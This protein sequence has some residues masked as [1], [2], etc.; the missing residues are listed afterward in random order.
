MAEHTLQTEQEAATALL[1][2]CALHDSTHVPQSRIEHL[3]R[4]MVLCT[5]FRGFDL[6]DL[7]AK[8]LALFSQEGAKGVIEKAAPMI[9]EDFRETLFAMSCELITDNGKVNEVESELL[10]GIALF[11]GMTMENMRMI[12]TT[13]LIRNRFSIQIVD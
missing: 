2:A 4:M 13:Y 3:S 12:L 6:N 9:S 7:S 5:R 10:G 11:L 8:A 1:F